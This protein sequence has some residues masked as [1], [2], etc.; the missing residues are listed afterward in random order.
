VA[1]GVGLSLVEGAERAAGGSGVDGAGAGAGSAFC[2]EPLPVDPPPVEPLPVEPPPV[3]PPPVEP[4]PLTVSRAPVTLEVAA[5]LAALVSATEPPPDEPV[6]VGADTELVS[7]PVSAIA[8]D[9]SAAANKKNAP[10][11]SA[12]TAFRL[13]SP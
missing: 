7:T 3:E 13:R 6:E 2:V 9:G 1:A 5:D 4:P 11:A 8:T 12:A 10:T